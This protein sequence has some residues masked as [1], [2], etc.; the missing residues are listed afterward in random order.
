M[1][2]SEFS[3]VERRDEA[4][5]LADLEGAVLDE[6]FYTSRNKVVISY[7]GVKEI[8]R[9]RGN[10]VTKL[11]QMTE[12]DDNWIVVISAEDKETGNSLLGTSVQ[13]KLMDNQGAVVPD[14]FCL[15]KAFSKAQRNAIKSLIPEAAIAKAIE[16]WQA[17]K[18][19]G[20]TTHTKPPSRKAPA[21]P[22]NVTD[23]MKPAELKVPDA[24]LA[25]ELNREEDSWDN[26][27]LLTEQW[28]V[29]AGINPYDFAVA[30]DAVKITVKPRKRVPDEM[31]PTLETVMQS[32]GF[33]PT[34]GKTK[35]WRMN[36]KDV[37]DG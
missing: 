19:G 23:F 18:N 8:A 36:K 22:I 35:T 21:K 12:T 7:T 16:I 37:V 1:T 31:M 4:Q 14:E 10:I 29:T 33:L 26:A 20:K 11:V 13:S 15:Q 24:S 5:I 6:Y 34:R 27:E 9:L 30:V 28:M 32:G 2:D 3:I 25:D 17:Q